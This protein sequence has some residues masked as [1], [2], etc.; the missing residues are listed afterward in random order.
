MIHD[1]YGGKVVLV[2]AAEEVLVMEEDTFLQSLSLQLNFCYNWTIQTTHLYVGTRTLSY[3]LDKY[4]ADQNIHKLNKYHHTIWIFNI[5]YIF[6][7]LYIVLETRI[8]KYCVGLTEIC[9]IGNVLICCKHLLCTYIFVCHILHT[10][11]RL[12]LPTPYLQTITPCI[13]SE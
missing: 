3:N 9:T 4:S 2:A 10:M 13:A 7:K 6:S 5:G 12:S 8:V 11:T 1:D